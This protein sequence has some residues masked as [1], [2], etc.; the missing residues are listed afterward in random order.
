M[1]TEVQQP[2][3]PVV[4]PIAAAVA[5]FADKRDAPLETPSPAV[6]WERD[7][8]G[9]FKSPEEQAAEAATGEAPADPFAAELEAW[10][11]EQNPDAENA[12]QTDE[13]PADDQEGAPEGDKPAEGEDGVFAVEIRGRREG[14]EPI[15]LELPGL[16]T[17]TQELVRAALN[18]GIRRDEFNRQQESLQR[19]R[20]EIAEFE[21]TIAADPV[22]VALQFMRKEDRQ[23]L[24]IALLA[25][26]A[27]LYDHIA[28]ETYGWEQDPRARELAAHKLRETRRTK[29]ES[30]LEELRGR[31]QAQQHA[32][33]LWTAV[34]GLVPDGVDETDAIDFLADSRS[35]LQGL[36]RER[37]LTVEEIPQL[38]E[39]RVSRYFRG[40]APAPANPPAPKP[41][42]NGVARPNGPEA[43][44][45]Q[46]QLAEAQATGRRFVQGSLRRKEAAASAPAGA[47]GA[48][49]LSAKLPA[50]TGIKDA[51]AHFRKQGHV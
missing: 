18:D 3:A 15:T 36:A 2:D 51:I 31:R 9:R 17:Q 39:R 4:N 7:E 6:Q 26:D 1:S 14:E 12:P 50:G 38:L 49:T 24:V 46:R 5:A 48:P 22:G 27:E 20:Q 13:V 33:N 45:L 37:D 44:A 47:G 25:E 21:D 8:K 16:D 10:Q 41:K 42:A 28:D 32:E 19:A 29:T 43:E 40:G 30:T 11:K 35:Y 23:N 34:T